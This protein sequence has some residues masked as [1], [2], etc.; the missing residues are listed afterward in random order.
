MHDDQ[1]GTAVV[2]LAGLINSLKLLGRSENEVKVVVN[3][4]ENIPREGGVILAAN[5][6]LGGLDGVAFMY[7]VGKYRQ[8]IRFFVNDLLLQIKNFSPLFVPVNKHGKNS[9]AY[10]QKFDEVYASDNC[11]II[12]PAGLVSRKQKG[13]I[14]EDLVWK[15]SFVTKAIQYHKNIV[16]VFIDGQNSRFFY[17]LAYWRKKI[18]IKANI[19]MFYLADEMYK[20]RGKTITF[21]F[22]EAISWETFTKNHTVEYWAE[23]LKRHTYALKTNDT[24]KMLPTIKNK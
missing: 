9:S 8:D 22:G 20:Q 11:L 10:F 5:H 15:K 1:H 16:P 3:G 14:I 7:A 2:A 19:E 23:K 6:P 17:N 4:A 24:S 13:G 18:G 12:F 21:T